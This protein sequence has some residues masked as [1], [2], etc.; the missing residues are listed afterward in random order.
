MASAPFKLQ[1]SDLMSLIDFIATKKFRFVSGG[2]HQS[3]EDV[4]KEC[5]FKTA[6]DFSPGNNK[7]YLLPKFAPC[8]NLGVSG[9]QNIHMGRIYAA[10]P[11]FGGPY[12][13]MYFFVK[14]DCD[15]VSGDVTLKSIFHLHDYSEVK[16][17]EPLKA[18]FKETRSF[19]RSRMREQQ[20]C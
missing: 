2:M 6:D 7:L 19:I 13:E 5:I 18:A 17:S 9:V 14:K 16:P 4:F 10:N 20:A 1:K 3:S 11:V 15:R 12:M 8:E